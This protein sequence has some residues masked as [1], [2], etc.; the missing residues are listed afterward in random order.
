MTGLDIY[1]HVRKYW[2]TIDNHSLENFLM[3]TRNRDE[4][5]KELVSDTNYRDLLK[6]LIPGYIANIELR[7]KVINR[8]SK[9]EENDLF[10]LKEIDKT[11]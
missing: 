6:D 7:N 11:K 8:L 5:Y 4:N 2:N 9:T 10:Y 3:V 1:D